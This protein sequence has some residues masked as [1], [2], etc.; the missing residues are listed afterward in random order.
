[1]A[2][3]LQNQ[4]IDQSYQK[5]VQ[6]SGSFIADGTGSLITNL[7]VTASHVSGATD[8][9]GQFTGSAGISGSL[10]VKGTQIYN[11]QVEQYSGNFYSYGAG[12]IQSFGGNVSGDTIGFT[13][14][15][16]VI[17]GSFNG[18][19][20]GL[21]N[22]TAQPSISASYAVSAS[23]AIKADT[24]TTSLLALDSL[25]ATY[26]T[27]S[28]TAVSA[29]RAVSSQTADLAAFATSA[30]TSLTATSSLAAVSSSYALTASYALT[31]E[32]QISSSYAI[33]ASHAILS[34]TA[35]VANGLKTGINININSISAS[36]ANFDSASINNLTSV[37]SSA[38]IIGDAYIV[39][40]NDTP[41][42]RFAGMIVRDS[43]SLNNT[44]SFEYDG[45]SDDWFFEKE[46]SGVKEFG[47]ALFGPEYTAKGVP[48]YNAANTILKGG[49]G[50]HILDSNITDNGSNV[51]LNSNTQ[52]TGSLGVT[53]TINGSITN[54][55]S[56]SHAIN[57]DNAISASHAVNADTSIT[58]T[59]AVSASH[60]VISDS[61]LT[62]LTA[63]SSSYA[64]SAS[65]SDFEKN[66]N[67]N[68][69]S[70]QLWQG[71]KTEY[72]LISGSAS[73]NNLYFVIE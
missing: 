18:D 23:H 26:A 39:L 42:Q 54:A 31:S 32:D 47:V 6:V 11:G 44:S 1:M 43:G 22:I 62:A 4:F 2:N 66:L 24:A 64:T 59:T 15:T 52:I 41:I 20:S 37:T 8:W 73:N 21:T 13:N 28:G 69:G 16:S 67:S 55:I 40:N 35:S 48:T 53:G 45:S 72:D 19:G 58:A 5:V 60:A 9:N 36:S 25:R 12:N 30:L 14:G 10:T 3:S 63:T 49:G 71:S 17:T 33:S 27:G 70:I 34:D 46:V 51:I 50:H 61:S 38:V 29:S 68:S 56:A 57:A 65:I 7:N